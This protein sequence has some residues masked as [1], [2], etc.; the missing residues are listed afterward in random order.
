VISSPIVFSKGL[1][2][3]DM[4]VGT[5]AVTRA[6]V[7]AVHAMSVHAAP[8]ID[9]DWPRIIGTSI[10]G[11]FPYL[12]KFHPAISIWMVSS[13]QLENANPVLGG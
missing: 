2:V 7:T 12:L 11:E 10:D 13:P 4:A 5:G 3:E 9:T 8:V 1:Q 6:P